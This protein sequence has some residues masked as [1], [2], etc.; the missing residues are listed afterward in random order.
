M[1]AAGDGQLCA[2]AE[3]LLDA[4]R[5]GPADRHDDAIELLRRALA[6]GEPGAVALL[7]RAYLE[8]GYRYEAVELL[9]PR[10]AAGRTELAGRLGDALAGID[11][12]DDAENAYR[13]AIATGQVGVANDLAVLLAD[14]GHTGEAAQLLEWAVQSGDPVA[15]MTLVEVWLVVPGGVAPAITAAER[16]A[17]PARPNT[18]VALARVRTAARRYDEAED[19][20]R[21]AC[22]RGAHRAHIHYGWFLQDVRSDQVAA[23]REYLLA[24]QADEPGW[25]LALGRFLLDVDRRPE[26]RS[27]LE[28]AALWGDREAAALVDTE[29][30]GIDPTDD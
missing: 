26:A 3:Q 18:L 11:D 13:T 24:R 20:Y 17:D 1:V 8:R 5:A 29:L 28:L 10:V 2:L 21:S 19:L 22:Q 12:Y 9:A 4:S 7:A 15:P 27:Y 16:L 25:A 23:E 14:R 6:A 30:D